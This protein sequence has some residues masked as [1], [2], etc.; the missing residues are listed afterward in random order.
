[1][2]EA[3]VDETMIVVSRIYYQ[4]SLNVTMLTPCRS[5]THPT[6][7]RSNGRAKRPNLMRRESRH[8]T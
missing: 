2:N 8:P 5:Q 1:M 3:N 4:A 6:Q 7:E